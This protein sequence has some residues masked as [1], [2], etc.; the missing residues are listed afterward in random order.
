VL[1]AKDLLAAER[2]GRRFA[3]LAPATGQILIPGPIVSAGRPRVDSAGVVHASPEVPVHGTQWTKYPRVGLEKK[4]TQKFSKNFFWC[5]SGTLGPW[6]LISGV[7]GTDR[8]RSGRPYAPRPPLKGDPILND[9]NTLREY[10][11]SHR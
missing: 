6:W 2:A 7:T 9:I 1:K 8:A 5:T 3:G 4:G 11:Y 10:T